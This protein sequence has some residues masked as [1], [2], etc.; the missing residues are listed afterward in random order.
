MVVGKGEIARNEGENSRGKTDTVAV[1]L[2]GC[3]RAARIGWSDGGAGREWRGEEEEA[4]Q[5]WRRGT[6]ERAME[7]AISTAESETEVNSD[8]T[9]DADGAL[10]GERKIWAKAGDTR[11]VKLKLKLTLKMVI[12]L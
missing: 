9:A 3:I 4:A 7:R 2:S 1:A 12:I 10:K 5:S 8:V 11:D 6:K